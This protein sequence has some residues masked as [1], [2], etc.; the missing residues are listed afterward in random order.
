LKVA[1]GDAVGRGAAEGPEGDGLDVDGGAECVEGFLGF[2]VERGF[3]VREGD[4]AFS[5]ALLGIEGFWRRGW[6][7]LCEFDGLD[8]CALVYVQQRQV[9]G[10]VLHVLPPLLCFLAGL[11]LPFLEALLSGLLALP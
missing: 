7:G 9:V 6:N 1:D 8:T 10:C 4:V 2:G 11:G 3:F 5:V